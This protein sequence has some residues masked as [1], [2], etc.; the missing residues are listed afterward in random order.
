MWTATGGSG[1]E[2][3]FWRYRRSTTQWI[4]AQSYSTNPALMWTPTSG[5][6]GDWAIEVWERAVG[7]GV[8]YQVWRSSGGFQVTP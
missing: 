3:Q 1:R 5:D 7:S 6:D 2:Y 8:P 4:L